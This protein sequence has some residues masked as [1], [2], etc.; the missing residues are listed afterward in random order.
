M[1]EFTGLDIL[2]Q[3]KKWR[4]FNSNIIILNAINL[5]KKDFEIYNEIGMFKVSI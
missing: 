2:N 1:P 5:K 3:L 4:A